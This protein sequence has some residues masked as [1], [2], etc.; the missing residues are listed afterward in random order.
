MEQKLE[1][2]LQKVQKPARYTGGEYNQV[3]K[4][5]S[6]VD[7]RVAFCFPDTYEIG[8]SNLGLR[9]LYG[10]LNSIEGV[11]CERVFAPWSDM[12]EQMRAEGI[13]LYGLESGDPV[14]DFD[15]VA[16]SLGYEL[17]YPNVLNMLDLAGIAPRSAD[18]GEG[19]PL[20]IAGGNCCYNPEPLSDFI[21]LFVIGEGEDA[22][23]E[24]IELI[25][26]A[27]CGMQKAESKGLER[28]DGGAAEK[29]GGPENDCGKKQFLRAAAGI[30]GVYVPSLYS[31]VYN[32]DGT[33]G[34]IE[35]KDGA[36]FPVYKR[37]VNDLDASFF[38]VKTIVPSTE[39]IHDRAVLELFRGCIRG[40]RFC[41]AGQVNRPLRSR[42]HEILIRQGIE[43]VT[44]SGY[45]E[46]AM[47][48]L[49]TSD[50]CELFELCDGLIDWCEPRK[51][52]LSLP[53][54]R[55]DNFSV[56]L[57]ERVQKVRKS[58]LTFAPEA[59]TQRLRDV[60]NKNI[61]EDDLLEACRIA[62]EGG[63]NGV[64][65]YFMLGLPTETDEDVIAIAAFSRA[66]LNSWKK[67]ALNKNRG[68]SINVTTSCFVPKPHTPFQWEPQIT[69]GEYLRRVELLRGAMRSKAIT[70][71]WHSPEQGYIEAALARGDR[72][73]GG[74]IEAAWQ[75]GARCDAWSE[76]FSLDRWQSAFDSLGLDPV[77]YALR[78]RER[79][80]MLPW[81]TVHAGVSEDHLWSERNAAREG[82]ITPDCREMCS[83]CGACV[84]G[85]Y[86]RKL[87][88]Y[89]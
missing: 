17:A 41:L 29:G 80:E 33:V 30:P 22:V 69:M 16:F 54:M 68:V 71:K 50:Y 8:M 42:T 25:R 51:I 5:K 53:S 34:M 39:L 84:V 56:E 49:S 61:T 18:R 20:V 3:I 83:A 60:V 15:I 88:T 65:L 76:N 21:D 89:E 12:E 66:I 13:A 73:L 87:M 43:V 59:G 40:C 52:S 63:W 24:I 55:A 10:L 64:K 6:A 38:P 44:D 11:W 86:G 72:R 32:D 78:E 58:G 79:E 31:V 46:I 14:R 81:K 70:Y 7:L 26:N 82:R 37:I 2:V 35:P 1:R 36:P 45:D 4:D 23:R 67:H 47:L 48:S 74:V 77:F 27:E 57:L 9:I 85:S 75:N 19:S 28:E 62:F